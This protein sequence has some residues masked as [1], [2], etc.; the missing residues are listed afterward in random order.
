MKRLDDRVWL[1][2]IVIIWGLAM[3]AYFAQFLR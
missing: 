1:V 3:I 2:A